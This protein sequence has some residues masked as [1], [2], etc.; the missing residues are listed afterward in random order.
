[1][2]SA[3]LRTLICCVVRNALS[4]RF[5]VDAG[6]VRLVREHGGM[7]DRY[8][9]LGDLELADAPRD[10]L[11]AFYAAW[12]DDA[13]HGVVASLFSEY[14]RAGKGDYFRVFYGRLCE[15]LPMAEI[16]GMLQIKLT[17]AE[18]HYRHVR[19]RLTARLK[20]HVREYVLRYSSSAEIGDE[21]AKAGK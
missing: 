18:N 17:S 9:E 14:D 19:D 4:N 21:F 10:Q 15:Q 11:D 5:R 7:L 13:L 6:R 3:K 12:V 2:R 1:M 16:A 20:E 8:A